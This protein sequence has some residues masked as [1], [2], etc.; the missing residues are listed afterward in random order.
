MPDQTKPRRVRKSGSYGMYVGFSR[1]LKELQTATKECRNDMHEPDETGLKVDIVGN[2]LD[3]ACGNHIGIEAVTGGFQEYVVVFHTPNGK[4]VPVN[5]A[6]I[7]ALARLADLQP[8]YDGMTMDEKAE[9]ARLESGEVS[10]VR[11]SP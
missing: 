5:L 4:H 6:N 10:D 2:H 3:N 1:V 7:I 9:I 11:D 8:F